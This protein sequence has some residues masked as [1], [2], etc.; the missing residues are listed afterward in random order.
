[1]LLLLLFELFDWEEEEGVNDCGEEDEERNRVL[2][3]TQVLLNIVGK[4]VDAGRRV[5]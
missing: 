5:G 4:I 1:M 3:V 2:I